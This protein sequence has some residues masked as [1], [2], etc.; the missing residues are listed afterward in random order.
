MCIQWGPNTWP[1]SLQNAYNLHC[2]RLPNTVRCALFSS[3]TV[4]VAAIAR[5]NVFLC[6]PKSFL[7][8]LHYIQRALLPRNVVD[9]V[10][11]RS[12]SL[13]LLSEGPS[14][15][16]RFRSMLRLAGNSN[17]YQRFTWDP[18]ERVICQS[19]RPLSPATSYE[20][21][22]FTTHVW[23]APGESYIVQYIYTF[24]FLH[25]V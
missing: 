18:A 2:H 17:L 8:Q 3:G 4:R 12:V 15:M 11:S 22:L 25:T 1:I 24:W 13:R 9:V 19:R 21:E 14:C 6:R 23:S 10:C 16:V 20:Q 5:H 7:H